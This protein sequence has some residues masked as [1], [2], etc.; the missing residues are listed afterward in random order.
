MAITGKGLYEKYMKVY[1]SLDVM[2]DHWDDL[3]PLDRQAWG[4]L[5]DE[6]LGE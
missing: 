6:L 1:E 3:D 4:R 2:V 5:A